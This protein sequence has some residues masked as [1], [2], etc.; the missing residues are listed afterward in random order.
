MPYTCEFRLKRQGIL[1]HHGCV[2]WVRHKRREHSASIAMATAS[3]RREYFYGC[4]VIQERFCCVRL[5]CGCCYGCCISRR[6]YICLQFLQ[7][8]VSPSRLLAR[9]L[10]VLGSVSSV[11]SVN[12]ETTDI[13]NRISN[14][15]GKVNRTPSRSESLRLHW[16]GEAIDHHIACSILWL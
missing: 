6:Q 2:Y 11:D 12:R 3:A 5:C 10:P 7:L 9:T 15:I 16:M 14:T 13:M 4:C 8:L 1:L